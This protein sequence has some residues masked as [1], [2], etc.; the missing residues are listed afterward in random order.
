MAKITPKKVKKLQV[1]EQPTKLNMSFQEFIKA[2]SNTPLKNSK[3][4]KK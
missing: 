4:N 3:I 2:A 1:K